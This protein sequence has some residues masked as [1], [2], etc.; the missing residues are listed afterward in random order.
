MVRGPV[1][2]IGHLHGMESKGATTTA[3][4]KRIYWVHHTYK[5]HIMR[6]HIRWTTQRHRHLTLL[7]F[8]TPSPTSRASGWRDNRRSR[9]CSNIWRYRFQACRMCPWYSTFFAMCSMLVRPRGH[10]MRQ[11]VTM[12]FCINRICPIAPTWSVMTLQEKKRPTG[13]R[14]PHIASSEG[15]SPQNRRPLLN[16]VSVNASDG[17]PH[18]RVRLP[19]LSRL[20][21]TLWRSKCGRWLCKI[22][23]QNCY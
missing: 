15:S 19:T 6:A 13:G 12:I 14:Q 10:T 1:A 4:R 2:G 8:S 7:I 21:R 23:L 17:R 20:A 16:G 3:L 5:T 11:T 18:K 9:R 22:D